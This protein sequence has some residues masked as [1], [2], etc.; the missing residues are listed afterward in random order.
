MEDK[1]EKVDRIYMGRSTIITQCKKI[2]AQVIQK[3]EALKGKSNSGGFSTEIEL[4]REVGELYEVAYRSAHK[5]INKLQGLIRSHEKRAEEIETALRELISIQKLSHTIRNARQPKEI[6]KALKNLI[7][8]VI[9]VIA[10][11]IFLLKPDQNELVPLLQ[12][13]G[14]RPLRRIITATIEE[15]IVDWVMEEQQ[16]KILG[17]SEMVF[18]NV[19]IQGNKS[20]IY[21]PLIFSGKSIG[22]HVLYSDAPHD[23]FSQQKLEL[24][25]M[26][27]EQAALAIENYFI[28][29]RVKESE[30]GRG[31][32]HLSI[33]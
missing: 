11:D 26:L 30:G 9:P 13:G 14:F 17:E 4:I 20:Y 31:A 16:T 25:T 2:Q 7:R 1:E 6:M 28:Q 24:L 15:G 32:C 19:T 29:Q 33:T 3:L 18:N 23:M 8:R 22:I 12:R 21:T 27:T 5:E 10:H